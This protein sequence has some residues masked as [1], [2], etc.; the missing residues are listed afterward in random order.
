MAHKWWSRPQGPKVMI[1]S[2]ASVAGT[3]SL[4]DLHMKAPWSTNQQVKHSATR[5]NTVQHHTTSLHLTAVNY[6]CLCEEAIQPEEA[7]G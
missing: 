3:S 2:C 6:C 5:C 7:S 1:A 4:T